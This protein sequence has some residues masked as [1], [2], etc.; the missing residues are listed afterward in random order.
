MLA[1][2]SPLYQSRVRS[3][4]DGV[5]V[6]CG[7]DGVDKILSVMTGTPLTILHAGYD[8]PAESRILWAVQS[9]F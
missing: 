1:N 2:I 4:M 9:A 5:Q 3:F 7:T 8:I 6:D